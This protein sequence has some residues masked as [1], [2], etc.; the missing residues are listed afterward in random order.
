MKTSCPKCGKE[1][2]KPRKTWKYAFY[3]VESYECTNCGTSF[4]DYIKNGSRVFTLKR[5]QGVK[6]GLVKVTRS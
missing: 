4:R 6:S 5:E 1:V 2:N 3:Q